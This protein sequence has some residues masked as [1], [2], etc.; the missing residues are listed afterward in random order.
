MQGL[1][2]QLWSDEA[3]GKGGGD[4]VIIKV[5]WDWALVDIGKTVN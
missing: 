1:Q 2:G 3:E 4:R 5:R